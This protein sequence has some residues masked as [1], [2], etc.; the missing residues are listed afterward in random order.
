MAPEGGGGGGLLPP[1]GQRVFGERIRSKSA[2]ILGISH[3]N[4]E[5]RLEC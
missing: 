3:K 4:E 2:S 5:E 1:L